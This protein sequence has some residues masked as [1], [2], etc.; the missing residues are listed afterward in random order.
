MN[1]KNFCLL[2][3]VLAGVIATAQG[4]SPVGVSGG[5]SLVGALRL[6]PVV[7]SLVAEHRL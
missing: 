3:D 2:I 7:A 6:L 4:L 5:Y 1:F